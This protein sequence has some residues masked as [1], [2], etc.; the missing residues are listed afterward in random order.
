[1]SFLV[2]TNVVSELT[3]PK[4]DQAVVDWMARNLDQVYISTITVG[5]LR[6]GIERLPIGKRKKSL[7]AWLTETCRIMDGRIL[8][9]NTSACHVW[10]QLRAK[11]EAEGLRVS[12][13]DGQIAA[14]AVRHSLKVATRNV[15][16]FRRTDVRT[17][18]PFEERAED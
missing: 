5:E 11:W 10:G 3:R 1:M 17:V 6:Y 7:H 4:P 8:S 18:N 13:I 2:D 15:A 16:D 12:V 9:F 14:I